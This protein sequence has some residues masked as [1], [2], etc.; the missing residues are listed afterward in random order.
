[1]R[2]NRKINS[3]DRLVQESKTGEQASIAIQITH[4]C[5]SYILTAYVAL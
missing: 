2:V 5:K 1:M 4:P 3:K